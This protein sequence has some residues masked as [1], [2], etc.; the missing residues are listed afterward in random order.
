M[1][2]VKQKMIRKSLTSQLKRMRAP[3]TEFYYGHRDSYTIIMGRRLVVTEMASIRSALVP[4][5][6]FSFGLGEYHAGVFSI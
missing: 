6:S 5:V 3:E 1:N 2:R 4:S